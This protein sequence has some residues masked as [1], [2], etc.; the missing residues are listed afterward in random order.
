MLKWLHPGCRGNV[1]ECYFQPISGCVVTAEEIL[2][3]EQQNHTS[4]TGEFF[5][6][7][8]LRNERVLM[9]HGLPVS[10]PCRL[11]MDKVYGCTSSIHTADKSLTWRPPAVDDE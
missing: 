5:D 1:F 10:G 8:P 6:V 7:Y 9:L 3:A 2:R 4:T 11:C